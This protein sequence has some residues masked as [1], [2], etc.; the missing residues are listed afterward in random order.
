[1][2][3]GGGQRREPEVTGNISK[4]IQKTCQGGRWEELANSSGHGLHLHM[5]PPHQQLTL[6]SD[7]PTPPTSGIAPNTSHGGTGTVQMGN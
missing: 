1:M 2:K 6:V 3:A 4:K 7:P 5:V